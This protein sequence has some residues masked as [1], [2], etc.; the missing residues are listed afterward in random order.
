[1]VVKEDGIFRVFTKSPEV[2]DELPVGVYLLKFSHKLGFHLIAK[3]DFSLP[4]KIYGDVS[5]VE[6][7]KSAWQ[8]SDRNLGILL[9]GDKGMGKTL[10]AK[11]FCIELQRPVI[12]IADAFNGVEFLDFMTSPAFHNTVI[13]IDEYEKIYQTGR[14]DDVDII[15]LMDGASQLRFVFLL[16]VNDPRINPLLMNRLGRIRYRIHY[17]EL[18]KDVV[19]EL[20]DDHLDNQEHRD[21]VITLIREIGV[22]SFDVVLTLIREMNLFKEDARACGRYLNLTPIEKQYEVTEL[23]GEEEFDCYSTSGR[24]LTDETIHV[25]RQITDYLPGELDP[26]Y[27]YHLH[28]RLVCLN[29]LEAK[30][31]MLT[32]GLYLVTTDDGLVFSF[33]EKKISD[34][35]VIADGQG[36]PAVIT[37]TRGFD[38][39]DE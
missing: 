22:V 37:R 11:K 38:F 35:N 28:S 23:I 33:K 4:E 29:L 21:S 31:E 5:S 16:T 10:L 20:L 15:S 27:Q 25:E 36:K 26:E 19:D 12:V 1:M 3:P 8:A 30:I 24:L 9:S 13:F 14:R 32:D 18:P 17:D 34:R 7:W 2:Y 6:R 39:I